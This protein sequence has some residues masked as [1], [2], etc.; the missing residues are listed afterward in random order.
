MWCWSLSSKQSRASRTAANSRSALPIRDRIDVHHNEAAAFKFDTSNWTK[1]PAIDP[2]IPGG[3]GGIVST[4][5]DLT[6]FI[7]A[8]F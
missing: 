3:A 5:N 7:H 4:P 1:V 2:I 6:D 8:L